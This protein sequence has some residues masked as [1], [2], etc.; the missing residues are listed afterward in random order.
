MRLEYLER[1]LRHRQ[2][3]PL[4]SN[5]DMHHGTCVT[6]VP[7]WMSGLLTHRG[8]IPGAYSTRNF[9]YLARGPW[10]KVHSWWDL[11]M[12]LHTHTGQCLPSL[13]CNE[14]VVTLYNLFIYLLDSQFL[15]STLDM[16]SCK[17]R[18]NVIS[19][20]LLWNPYFRKW[21]K[22]LNDLYRN[23]YEHISRALLFACW[24]PFY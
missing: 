15:I 19:V 10:Q 12:Q 13:F 3:K 17:G 8:G 22:I 21:K 23:C 18:Q 14:S 9:T 5:P 6:H 11:H 2:R 7:W 16:R 1:F 4:V 24:S 20:E